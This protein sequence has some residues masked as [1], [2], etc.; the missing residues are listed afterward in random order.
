MTRHDHLKATASLDGSCQV[1]R[2][3]CRGLGMRAHSCVGEARMRHRVQSSTLSILVL[4]FPGQHEFGM[5]QRAEMQRRQKS[6]VQTVGINLASDVPIWQTLLG[7]HPAY[8]SRRVL[9]HSRR[10]PSDSRLCN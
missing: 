10:A 3:D 6:T 5:L 4:F 9:R 1:A 7:T 2:G 8:R